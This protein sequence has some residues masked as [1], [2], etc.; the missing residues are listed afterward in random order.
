MGAGQLFEIVGVL[1]GRGDLVVSAGPFA[2]VNEAAA[3]G[4]EGK[5]LV[6]GEDDFAAGGTEE[7]FGHGGNLCRF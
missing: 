5:V 7:G 3:V 6:G 2:E 4:A 1:N